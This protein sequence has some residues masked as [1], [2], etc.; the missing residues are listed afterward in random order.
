MYPMI[1]TRTI[2]CTGFARFESIHIPHRDQSHTRQQIVRLRIN[3]V[4]I[5]AVWSVTT[6]VSIRKIYQV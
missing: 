1:S 3:E 6:C 5:L 4:V 2:A